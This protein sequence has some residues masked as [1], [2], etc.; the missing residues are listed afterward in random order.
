MAVP[1]GNL[2]FVTP[3]NFKWV[4]QEALTRVLEVLEAN[5]GK[6]HQRTEPLISCPSGLSDAEP[7]ALLD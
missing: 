5:W 1:W 6:R 2:G 7:L 3:L 4:H